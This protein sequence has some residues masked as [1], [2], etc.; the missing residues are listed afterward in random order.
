MYAHTHTFRR[1]LFFKFYLL[2]IK[3]EDNEGDSM[4]KV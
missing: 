4:A 2:F 1:F 3:G